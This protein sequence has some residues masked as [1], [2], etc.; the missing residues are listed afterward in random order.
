M[1]EQGKVRF[2][3]RVVARGTVGYLDTSHQKFYA[4]TLEEFHA[5]LMCIVMECWFFKLLEKE[6]MILHRSET[7]EIYFLDLIYKHLEM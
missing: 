4:E 6:N 7:S 3:W 5:S 1:Q 2:R